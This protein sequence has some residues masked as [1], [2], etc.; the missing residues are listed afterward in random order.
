MGYSRVSKIIDNVL[1][2]GRKEGYRTTTTDISGGWKNTHHAGGE[3]W[4]GS[5]WKSFPAG[6]Q[7]HEIHTDFE[8]HCGS[9]S[10]SEFAERNRPYDVPAGQTYEN[11]FAGEIRRTKGRV[12]AKKDYDGGLNI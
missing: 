3:H 10:R 5:Y 2:E 11:M 9:H 12:L 8:K 6:T 1:A 4:H 7:D